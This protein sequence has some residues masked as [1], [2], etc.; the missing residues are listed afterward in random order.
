LT[1][2]YRYRAA[3]AFILLAFAATALLYGRLPDLIPLRWELNGRVSGYAPKWWGA[4]VVPVTAAFVSVAMMYLLSARRTSTTMVNAVAGL[5]LFVCGAMLYSAIHP[6]DPPIAYVFMGLG[7]FL[8][9]VGN[10]LGKLTWNY[11]VGIRTYWTMDDPKVWERTHR[12]AGPVFMLGGLALFGAGIARAPTPTLLTL[13][14]ATC[15][16]PI[17]YSYFV[18]RRG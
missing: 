16:Y 5:M 18:W 9:V 11:F 6:A 2:L 14:F 1:A 13:L 4:W 12:V 10:I 7:V 17:V 8:V 15:L 3:V